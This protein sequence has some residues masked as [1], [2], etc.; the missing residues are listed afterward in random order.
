MVSKTCIQMMGL[1]V[2]VF[3]LEEYKTLPPNTPVSVIFG[4]HGKNS[5]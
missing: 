1:E 3:G 5:M 4:L 2:N